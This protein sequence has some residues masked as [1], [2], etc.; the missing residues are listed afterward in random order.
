M[1]AYGR[2]PIPTPSTPIALYSACPMSSCA[3]HGPVLRL[4]QT[5]CFFFFTFNVEK[6]HF[7]YVPGFVCVEKFQIV[8]KN[9]RFVQ[10][11]NRKNP[12]K[13]LKNE[14]KFIIECKK[15][16]KF[17]PAAAYRQQKGSNLKPVISYKNRRPK[18]G[19]NFSDEIFVR[20]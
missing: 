2:Y 11:L 4:K 18:G 3:P 9:Y 10:K 1:D 8:Q 14:G 15:S 17:S 20:F 7:F 5:Q 19:E 16:F 6:F 13:L 12:S